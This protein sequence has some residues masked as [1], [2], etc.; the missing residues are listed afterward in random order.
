MV[1]KSCL[2]LFLL[3]GFEL[4]FLF[5]AGTPFCANFPDKPIK[6][7]VYQG[8]GSGTDVEARGILPYVQKH[9]GVSIIIENVTGAGG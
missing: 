1:R 3:L 2:C 6:V 4:T 5:G 7:I 8:P 9:L